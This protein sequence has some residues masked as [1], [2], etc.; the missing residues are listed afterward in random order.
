[1]TAARTNGNVAVRAGVFAVA[2]CG[3]AAGL[4]CTGDEANGMARESLR[5]VY[6]RAR[7]CALLEAEGDLP[8]FVDEP[9]EDEEVA[10]LNDCL[11]RSSCAALEPVF[12]QTEPLV[13]SPCAAR[14]YSEA[15]DDGTPLPAGY[16]CDGYDDCA[17]HSDESG[18][19]LF[20]CSDGQVVP[21]S[22]VCSGFADCVDGSDERDCEPPSP[23]PMVACEDG[24]QIPQ[25]EYCDGL[26]DCAD[27][28]DE[29]HCAEPICP[30]S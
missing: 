12:C 11:A 10:C 27:Q 8:G 21:Q 6:E 9:V 15:S 18:C 16:V 26:P 22:F 19:P 13:D 17:D 30:G 5:D 3:A 1:M 25:S 28:S 24:E 20:T 14:C 2:L 29:A 7:A 4:A 23:P